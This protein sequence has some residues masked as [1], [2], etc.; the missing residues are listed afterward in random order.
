MATTSLVACYLP[1][2]KKLLRGVIEKNLIWGW[3]MNE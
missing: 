1:V 3:Q 2:S